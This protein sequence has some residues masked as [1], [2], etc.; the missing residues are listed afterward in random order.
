MGNYLQ[1][2]VLGYADDAALVS[3]STD[4]LSRG[5]TNISTG[6][7]VEADMDLHKSKTKAMHVRKQDHLVPPPIAKIKKTEGDYKHQCKF[8]DRKCKTQ[9]GLKIHMRFCNSQHELTE[10]AFPV[11]C[12]NAVFGTPSNRSFRVEW[13]GYPGEDSWE[14][15]RSLSAQGCDGLIQEFWENTSLSPI[16]EFI[17]DP[18]DI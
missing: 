5:L 11:D 2:G 16:T 3:L 7:C 1:V 17:P 8:C 6:S 9:R 13:K 4:L 15:E 18:D 10:A 12:I 14:P